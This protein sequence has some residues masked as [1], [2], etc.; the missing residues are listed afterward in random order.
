MAKRYKVSVQSRVYVL[1]GIFTCQEQASGG[2]HG[3]GVGEKVSEPVEAAL[4]SVSGEAMRPRCKEGVAALA[5]P[6]H[7]DA[8]VPGG[9]DMAVI[10][11]W[12]GHESLGTLRKLLL[13]ACRIACR[14]ITFGPC[15]T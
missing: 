4:G 2:Q 13:V 5:A 12:L 7:G 11:L 8:P 1:K 9:V 3:P 15:R 6:Q 14:A 10:A